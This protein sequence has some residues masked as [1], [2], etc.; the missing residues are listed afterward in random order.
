VLQDID[1]N[2]SIR[3]EISPSLRFYITNIPNLDNTL[4]RCSREARYSA[5]VSSG[6]E[7]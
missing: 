3:R 7:D 5:T 1:V 6:Q 2:Y 4:L